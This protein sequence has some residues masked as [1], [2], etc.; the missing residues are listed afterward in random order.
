[1]I[2]RLM[3]GGLP[4]RIEVSRAAASVLTLEGRLPW[5]RLNR[6]VELLSDSSGEI[7]YRLDFGHDTQGRVQVS[8][9]LAG[10]AS[11][12]CQRCLRP[13]SWRFELPVELQ[14]VQSE[15]EEAAARSDCL[16]VQ[17]DAL[18]PRDLIED[19]LLLA[20][21]SAPKH[22]DPAECGQAH[23]AATPPQ[24]TEP[25]KRPFAALAQLKTRH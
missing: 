5:Q 13:M 18:N 16:L 20:L 12:I 19:E 6:V 23:I 10:K 14:L 2:A 1:M 24:E 11:L 3:S 21:P 7:S 25:V 8:G 15:A 22:T 4:A 9:M 17:D